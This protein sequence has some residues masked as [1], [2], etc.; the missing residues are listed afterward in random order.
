[1]NFS[2][3]SNTFS[4][5]AYSSISIFGDL[6]TPIEL[7]AMNSTHQNGAISGSMLHFGFI[8]YFA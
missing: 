8:F 2:M 3:R 5:V 7:V 6:K 1:M 4:L